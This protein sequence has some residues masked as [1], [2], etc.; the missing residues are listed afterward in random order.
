MAKTF[1][2]FRP[3][4]AL[5]IH[6]CDVFDGDAHL[7]AHYHY[8]IVSVISANNPVAR[9][10]N[11]RL[12][13]EFGP[14]SFG[15]WQRHNMIEVGTFENFLPMLFAQKDNLS[16]LS[17]IRDQDPA[18]QGVQQG[19]DRAL[20]DA[21]VKGFATAQDPFEFQAYDKPAFL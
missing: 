9:V 2:V 11:G 1:P 20:F 19:H 7:G 6:Y 10:L 5:R 21:G 16:T 3:V 14:E 12:S 17:F 8:E 18:P 4:M 13:S 15:A